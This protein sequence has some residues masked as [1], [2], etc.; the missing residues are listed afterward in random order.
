MQ[1]KMKN[2]NTVFQRIY[3]V[4]AQIP[5][6]KVL[7]YKAVAEKANTNPRVVGFAMHANK[8][9]FKIPCHRIVN[10]DGSMAKG[11]AFGG[12]S[13]KLQKLREEGVDFINESQVNLQKSLF[14]FES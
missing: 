4:V 11:Y 5:R 2:N 1:Q 9:P 13:I 7:T 8:N 10:H 12:V 6:G 14:K 3:A